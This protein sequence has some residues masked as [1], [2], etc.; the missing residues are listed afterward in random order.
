MK[1]KKYYIELINRIYFLLVS[2]ETEDPDIFISRVNTLSYE[3]GG[4]NYYEGMGRIHRKLNALLK[5]NEITHRK[6]KSTVLDS[7]DIIDRILSNWE[8]VFGDV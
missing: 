4:D 2:F 5:D 8:V 1:N 6:V 3:V 7:I